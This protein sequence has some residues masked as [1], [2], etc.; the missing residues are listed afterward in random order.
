MTYIIDIDDTLLI[1]EK[2][3]CKECS[4]VTYKLIDIFK[5]EIKKVNKLYKKGHIIILWTGRGW[6][7][8][9]ITKMQLSAC[10]IK[11]QELI[12]GKP[13]GIYVDRDAIRSVDEIV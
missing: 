6:D 3:E 10:R 2:S 4:R 5:D 7:Y 1:S 9:R 8:Y 12:M 11:Y 13:Q